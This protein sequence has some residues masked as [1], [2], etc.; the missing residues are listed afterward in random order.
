MEKTDQTVDL[1]LHT[2]K[3]DG[4]LS[5]IELVRHAHE[6]GL[7][8]MAITDHDTTAGVQEGREEAERLGIGFVPG[9]EISS[10]YTGGVLHILGYG[11]NIEDD[12]LKKNLAEFQ[13]AR[14]ERNDR[15]ISKLQKLGVDITIEELLQSAQGVS[16]L[17]RP[18]IAT[19]LI[20][21]GM[22]VITF[23]PEDTKKWSDGAK[24]AGWDELIE[25]S[26]EHGPALMK[27]F[28]K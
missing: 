9:V 21:K 3:S 16:S 17:G 10:L 18:H 20:K 23:S 1:H 13:L 7:S 4:T 22:T 11:V 24:K 19:M 28:T 15:I 8:L 12:G 2:T 27:L 14:R 26:P 6:E 25:R 5:P